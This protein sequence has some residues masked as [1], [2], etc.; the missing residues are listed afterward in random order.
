MI[1]C[2]DGK[3]PGEKAYSSDTKSFNDVKERT[4]W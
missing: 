1:Y 3:Q 2:V 4:I